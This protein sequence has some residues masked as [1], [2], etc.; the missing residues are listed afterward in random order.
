MALIPEAREL[1]SALLIGNQKYQDPHFKEL[2]YCHSDV[3]ALE[4]TLK[5]T[6]GFQVI[7]YK[8]A[9]R[10][11]FPTLL[12]QLAQNNSPSSERGIILVHY[13]G[14]AVTVAGQDFLIP[15]DAKQDQVGTYLNVNEFLGPLHDLCLERSHKRPGRI[16]EEMSARPAP[17]ALV[18]FILDGCREDFAPSQANI[19]A[20]VQRLA[21]GSLPDTQFYT[22]FA[23]DAGELAAEDPHTQHGFLT[24][25]FLYCVQAFPNKTLPELIEEVK[26]RCHERS[27]RRQRVWS[28]ECAR[29]ASTVV[30]HQE[31]YPRTVLPPALD[32][33]L[34]EKISCPESAL[35]L[36]SSV[37]CNIQ[38][39]C[40]TTLNEAKINASVDRLQAIVQS[41]LDVQDELQEKLALLNDAAASLKSLQDF[42]PKHRAL[43][44]LA[45]KMRGYVWLQTAR[46]CF[47]N[48]ALRSQAE[49]CIQES[50]TLL[51]QVSVSVAVV[52][53]TSAGKSTLVNSYF[54][55]IVCPMGKAPKSLLPV[56]F[57]ANG[58]VKGF[59]VFPRGRGLSEYLALQGTRG[60]L[61]AAE[62][63]KLISQYCKRLRQ[64]ILEGRLCPEEEQGFETWH[65]EV[66]VPGPAKCFSLVDCPGGSEGPPVGHAVTRLLQYQAREACLSLLAPRLVS[67]WPRCVQ[68]GAV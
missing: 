46:R 53:A 66:M 43:A 7:K 35:V 11:D 16:A 50:R 6:C 2:R 20:L 12:R 13:S 15:V 64:L 23:C 44:T 26:A 42:L 18:F 67:G 49:R 41:L 59:Q 51:G 22:L 4:K 21:G 55:Q 24:E 17:G 33:T 63:H 62:A 10:S 37:I 54:G 3:D 19:E 34:M 48:T 30:L 25:A 39:T 40:P 52:G 27:K 1:R 45:T 60:N 9:K 56:M 38:D 8:D 65:M 29:G 47:A 68:F 57:T 58:A 14:H 28:F 32:Y 5:K 61:S 31:A 36:L